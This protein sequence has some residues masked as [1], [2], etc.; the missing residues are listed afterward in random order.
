MQ[1]ASLHDRQVCSSGI[2]CMQS[3]IQQECDL[4]RVDARETLGPATSPE[5]RQQ[6]LPSLSCS[7]E[8]A[9]EIEQQGAGPSLYMSVP[10]TAPV[11]PQVRLRVAKGPGASPPLQDSAADAQAEP[12]L[13]AEASSDAAADIWPANAA[14]AS[15]RPFVPLR[16]LRRASGQVRA[17][18]LRFRAPH[19]VEQISCHSL[20]D[21]F[22]RRTVIPPVAVQE[23]AA[24]QKKL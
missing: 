4:S 19:V 9:A 2:T 17:V 14:L 18:L 10:D 21:V 23:G 7:A 1:A 5:R 8:H 13:A 3:W 16:S 12:A 24:Q 11:E 22:S 6:R 20:V 15:G